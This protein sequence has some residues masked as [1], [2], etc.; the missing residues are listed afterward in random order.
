MYVLIGLQKPT[1]L[2]PDFCIL[3]RHCISL[4]YTYISHSIKV[5]MYHEHICMYVA[6]LLVFERLLNTS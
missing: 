2:S 5:H 1:I 6:S 4:E 3:R